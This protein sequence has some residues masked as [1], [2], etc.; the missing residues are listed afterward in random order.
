MEI[1]KMNNN[2]SAKAFI[3]LNL[4]KLYPLNISKIPIKKLLTMLGLASDFKIKI[5]KIK[6]S[7]NL[8]FFSF[9]KIDVKNTAKVRMDNGK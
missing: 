2:E 8:I 5:P 1:S 6:K 9:W 7:I 4:W 3:L